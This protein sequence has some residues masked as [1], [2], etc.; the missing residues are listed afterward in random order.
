MKSLITILFS[1][2]ILTTDAN[3]I[4]V[5][6]IDSNA[7]ISNGRSIGPDK[8]TGANGYASTNWINTLNGQNEVLEFENGVESSVNIFSR[9]PNG[10]AYIENNA[11]IYTNTPLLSFAKAWLPSEQEPHVEL[12]NLNEN[13]PNGYSVIVYVSGGN[14]NQGWSVTLNE[15]VDHTGYNKLLGTTYF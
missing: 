11:N 8:S 2:V 13:F 5:N 10:S 14:Q 9:R 15:D 7:T 3:I 12:S 4:S 6:F 1:T